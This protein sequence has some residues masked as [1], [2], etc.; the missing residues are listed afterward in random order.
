M[1]K[2]I[3]MVGCGG[4]GCELLKLLMLKG[5]K[6]ITIVD[7]DTIEVTN[8]NRQFFF[9]RS[10]VGKFKTDIT[11]QYYEQM[12]RD[13]RVI[14]YN[15]NIIN[16]KFDLKFFKTFEIV[17]NCLDN[18]EAR[19]YVNLRCRLARVPLVDG[20]SAGYL[21]QSMVFFENECYDCTPKV[22]E[23]S[24]P[25]CTIR[26]RP[27]SF[28][29]CVAYAKEVVYANIR[30]KR[31]R[32]KGLENVCRFL[33]GSGECDSSKTKIA[34]KIMKY[35]ARLKKSNFPVFNKDNRNINKFIYYVA[36]ARASNYD[37]TVENFFTAERIVKNIIPSICTTNAAVASLMLISAARLTH[38]YFLTKNKKLIIKNYPGISSSTCGICGV[39]WFVLHLNNNVL[40]IS[41]FLEK[42]GL[43]S[44]I[45]VINNRFHDSQRDTNELTVSHNS[46]MVVKSGCELFKFYINVDHR[47]IFNTEEFILD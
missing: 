39:K 26:G 29:H 37:I 5:I 18:V 33:F 31:A 43:E 8:L 47:Y 2:N 24:F 1:E 30:K 40:M 20:G 23:Q 3:L 46:I 11:K 45:F 12:V 25:I 22:Q 21:G 6:R 7:N 27:Q 41:D 13:A 42:I 44:A 4:I 36:L 17:Y 32:Y 19:S 15:E 34:K 9:T 38:N 10:N 16:E 14:S 35:H 28:V